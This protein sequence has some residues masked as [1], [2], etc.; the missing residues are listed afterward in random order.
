D[1]MLRI[2][3]RVPAARS[4]PTPAPVPRAPASPHAPVGAT[5]RT[6][7]PSATPAHGAAIERGQAPRPP[8][9]P[10]GPP[11]RDPHAVARA[12]ARA[13]LATG[14][15]ARGRAD[16][17]GDPEPAVADRARGAGRIRWSGRRAVGDRAPA[18]GPGGRGSP[19]QRNGPPCRSQPAGAGPCGRRADRP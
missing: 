6:Q 16:G 11:P 18:R 1:V 10:H 15:P 19:A 13:P 5:R 7:A 2:E 8:A 14:G 4:S 12:A 9:H 3:P 17:G